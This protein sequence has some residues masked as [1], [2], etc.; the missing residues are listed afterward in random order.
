MNLSQLRVV[1]GT[2]MRDL[3]GMGECTCTSVDEVV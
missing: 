2:E 1:F 3:I